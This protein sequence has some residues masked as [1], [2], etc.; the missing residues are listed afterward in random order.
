MDEELV[1]ILTNKKVKGNIKEKLEKL[2]LKAQ[3]LAIR[4]DELF[5]TISKLQKTTL[6]IRYWEEE[7]I[8]KMIEKKNEG[9]WI[10]GGISDENW[11]WIIDKEVIKNLNE[12][13]SAKGSFDGFMLWCGFDDKKKFLKVKKGKINEIEMIRY[14][15]KLVERTPK[16]FFTIG[17]V[18]FVMALTVQWIFNIGRFWNYAFLLCSILMFVGSFISCYIKRMYFELLNWPVYIVQE[19]INIK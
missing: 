17:M 6:I 11:N 2:N 15:E 16:I 14:K 19:K 3:N 4:E 9:Y 18:L 7:L 13:A 10:I 1:V 12:I 5:E 8:R